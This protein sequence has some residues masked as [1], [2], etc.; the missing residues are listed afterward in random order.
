MEFYKNKF[1][2]LIVYQ[3]KKLLKINM[4]VAKKK[5]LEDAKKDLT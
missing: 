3:I 2:G 5:K 1:L 4:R